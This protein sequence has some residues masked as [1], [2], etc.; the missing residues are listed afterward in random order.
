M[1]NLQKTLEEGEL[2]WWRVISQLTGSEAIDENS[3]GAAVKEKEASN[4][5]VKAMS[6]FKIFLFKWGIKINK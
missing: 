2:S 3:H 1:K 4:M 6:F 5:S